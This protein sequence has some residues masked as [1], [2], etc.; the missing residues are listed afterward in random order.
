MAGPL[1]ARP[2][3]ADP[4]C[5]SCW[6][7]TS[8]L[9]KASSAGE[10][11]R[12]VSTTEHPGRCGPCSDC[13][14]ALRDYE[15]LLGFVSRLL[16]PARDPL[17]SFG[18]PPK[19]NQKLQRSRVSGAAMFVRPS[20][21]KL[22]RGAKPHWVVYI[23]GKETIPTWP[24]TENALR[25]HASRYGPEGVADVAATSLVASEAQAIAADTEHSKS[26]KRRTTRTLR[27]QVVE[28]RRRGLIPAAIADTL[29]VADRRVKEIL[30]DAA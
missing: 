18:I 14:A 20:R 19:L 3:C 21:H 15:A 17:L 30:R 6:A 7:A 4:W 9:L 24:V 16:R 25:L 10:R 1:G 28:L 12:D 8:A 22:P 29:N 26:R 5:A 23:R 11:R 2:I 27:E 13:T